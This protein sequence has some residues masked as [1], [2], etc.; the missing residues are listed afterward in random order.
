MVDS[1]TAL[2][3]G[4]LSAGNRW[5][6][7]GSAFHTYLKGH[8]FA[9][10]YSGSDPFDWRP[11]RRTHR[12]RVRGAE[13][14]IGWCRANPARRYRFVGHSHG[15]NVANL[16][17]KW[18]PAGIEICT[19]IHLSPP[20]MQEYLP[21]LDFVTSGRF[22]AVEAETDRIVAGVAGAKQNYQ[23]YDE[24]ADAE[25]FVC[26]HGLS[27]H[28]DSVRKQ[29]WIDFDVA[30][31]VTPVCAPAK[32]ALVKGAKNGATTRSATKKS[33]VKKGGAKKT[34]TK[35]VAA[36]KVAAKKA[37]AKKPSKRGKT[38]PGR[39]VPKK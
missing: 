15:A 17:T 3:H 4:T 8:G 16:V 34:A 37:S 30:N 19:L 9:D 36:K 32:Q 2:I 38:R 14:L 39:A 18:E 11:A 1:L 25:E 10:V 33:A 22:F 23:S 12:A 5:Y 26:L 24:V 6:Q 31:L 13:N 29:P 35:R 20:A 28:W 7:P 27:S 21:N